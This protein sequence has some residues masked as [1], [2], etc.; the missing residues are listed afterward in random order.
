LCIEDELLGRRVN[1]PAGG[2]AD[3]GDARRAD[4]AV[5][6]TG[7]SQAVGYPVRFPLVMIILAAEPQL[8][9]HD[10]PPGRAQPAC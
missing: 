6:R 7:G 1:G 4:R 10:G 8:G 3:R 9:L 2:A 5:R